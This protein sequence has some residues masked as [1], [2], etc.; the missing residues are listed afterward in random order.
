MNNELI[1]LFLS[2]ING[3]VI[4]NGIIIFLF[5]Q[6]LIFDT[7]KQDYLGYLKNSNQIGN[8]ASRWGVPT[9]RK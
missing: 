5:S 2:E 3:I 1:W 6:K 4:I 8:I 7:K 9:F